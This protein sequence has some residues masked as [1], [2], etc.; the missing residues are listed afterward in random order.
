MMADEEI[1]PQKSGGEAISNGLVESL[2]AFGSFP[3]FMTVASVSGAL[4][5]AMV[6]ADQHIAH[7][8]LR[9]VWTPLVNSGIAGAS[10]GILCGA[11][12]IAAY[13][14]FH[15]GSPLQTSADRVLGIIQ[16][17]LFWTGV[18]NGILVGAL[19]VTKFDEALIWNWPIF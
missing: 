5:P 3:F 4:L 14:L 8:H 18:A 6:V 11:F 13:K 15:P 2:V 9:I 12:C 1:P 19:T 10:L 17:P 16:G 7:P